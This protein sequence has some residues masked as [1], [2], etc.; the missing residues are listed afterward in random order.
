MNE[1]VKNVYIPAEERN[2]IEVKRLYDK[3]INAG[4][5]L[6]KNCLE[7]YSTDM[8]ASTFFHKEITKHAENKK[9]LSEEAWNSSKIFYRQYS[10]I[11][12]QN[13]MLKWMILYQT[14]KLL[15]I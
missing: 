13:Y 2:K 7:N 3:C 8:F 15:V 1:L 14:L 6:D 10:L 9:I 5:V 12:K 11:Q 4:I